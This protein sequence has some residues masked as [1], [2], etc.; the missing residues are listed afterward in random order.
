MKSI[1][2]TKVLARMANQL[3]RDVITMLATS[4]S[5]HPAGALGMADV[6]AVLYF[7]VLN[8]FPT[9][10]KHPKR[11]YL[12][13]SNGHICPVLY[14]A[15]ARRGFFSVKQLATLRS[16]G[17]PLQ[18]HPHREALPGIET[19]SGPL[20]SGL[21]QAAGMALGL[22]MDRKPNNVFCITSDGE[23][24]EGNTWEAVLF[25]AKYRLGNLVQVMDRNHIQI[26]GNTEEVM[27]LASL[28]KKYEAFGWK[29]ISLDGHDLSALCKAF[30]KAKR[31]TQKPV[32]ILANTVPG[33]GVS[34]MENKYVWH[35]K[36]PSPQQAQQALKE[37]SL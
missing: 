31:S 22:R 28:Q 26:D 8:I 20:G 11:D 2:T 4:L 7:Q 5:G 33:K 18:G 25:A 6:F 17:S 36:P 19:S 23:H 3:R 21:S 14:A 13:L 15:L 32:L 35:G 9:Q 27:P 16:F 24:D 30:A 34:F 10:P 12:V 29:V 37:L 1:K